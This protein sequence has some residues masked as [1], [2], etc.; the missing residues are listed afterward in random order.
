MKRLLL[1]SLLST[2]TTQP[3][4]LRTTRESN[5]PPSYSATQLLQNINTNDLK[6]DLQSLRASANILCAQDELAQALKALQLY[7]TDVDIELEAQS[8][9]KLLESTKSA[10]AQPLNDLRKSE[11]VKSVSSQSNEKISPTAMAFILKVSDALFNQNECIIDWDSI[12]AALDSDDKDI[13]DYALLL[14]SQKDNLDAKKKSLESLHTLQ[15]ITE[16]IMRQ[17]KINIPTD[18]TEHAK[19]ISKFLKEYGTL[20][21]RIRN[22]LIDL[23][24]RSNPALETTTLAT[25]CESNAS[26]ADVA[27]QITGKILPEHTR[28]ALE[29]SNEKK[30]IDHEFIQQYIPIRNSCTTSFKAFRSVLNKYSNDNSSIAANC[31]TKIYDQAVTFPRELPSSIEAQELPKSV[32]TQSEIPPAQD[33]ANPKMNAKS[34]KPKKNKT[35]KQPYKTSNSESHALVVAAAPLVS[36]LIK[37]AEPESIKS[38]AT[39]RVA[40]SLIKE[41]NDPLNNMTIHLYCSAKQ[42]KEVPTFA[43]HK[44]LIEWFEDGKATLAKQGYL[45]PNNPKHKFKD[46]ALAHHSFSLDVDPIAQKYGCQYE[47]TD[48]NGN[49]TLFVAI[50]G[51][52][53]RNGAIT[54]GIF[55]YA[56][57]PVSKLCYHR[58]FEERTSQELLN[59][60]L[61][62]QMWKVK[63]DQLAHA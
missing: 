52:I 53:E 3:M 23:A 30:R 32:K 46:T 2:F 8:V 5:M 16:K 39:K 17:D 50:P 21:L 7:E 19:P 49:R 44:R 20:R 38:K 31:L 40:Q 51:H 27:A 57:D 29:F 12:F 4:L 63:L 36:T 54:F 11:Y 1:L 41:I 13:I 47:Q 56:I 58:C 15:L 24:K 28:A 10:S 61:D 6:N 48:K 62:A 25:L 37:T 60:Y 42:K 45:D 22:Y 43:R 18:V 55:G 9:K 26:L 33:A 59:E 35:K 14:I 34:S